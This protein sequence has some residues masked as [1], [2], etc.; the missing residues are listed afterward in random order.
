[1]SEYPLIVSVVPTGEV[2][3]SPDGGFSLPVLFTNEH[4]MTG[5]YDL[6]ARRKKDAAGNLATYQG[7]A[8]DGRLRASIVN[9][10]V[11]TTHSR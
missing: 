1:M 9:G 2:R 7:W 10:V 5:V 4:G 3:N 8:R 11:C 6:Y